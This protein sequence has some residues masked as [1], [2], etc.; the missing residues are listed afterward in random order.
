MPLIFFTHRI[1]VLCVRNVKYYAKIAINECAYLCD[2]CI[3]F[4]YCAEI[5]IPIKTIFK[6]PDGTVLR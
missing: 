5:S 6:Y 2:N 3:H 4:A 1:V